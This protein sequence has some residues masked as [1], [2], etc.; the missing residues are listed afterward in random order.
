MPGIDAY[1]FG[2][3]F[4]YPEEG[5]EAALATALLRLGIAASRR[6]DGGFRI[7]ESD[8]PAFKMYAGGRVRYSA[9]EVCGLPAV[10]KAA[11][12]HIPTIISSVLSLFLVIFLSGLVWD[13]RIE[14]AESIPISEIEQRVEQS[15]LGIGSSW[16]RLDTSE[17]ETAILSSAPE[18]AWVQIN[19]VG[20]VAYVIVREREQIK[21]EQIEPY[22]CSN[23]VASSDGVI[24]E[25]TVLEGIALVKPGD[26][27]KMGD[28][29]ISGITEDE[30]GTVF[31]AAK[32]KV[33]AHTAGSL[34]ATAGLSEREEV[35]GEGRVCA[36]SLR[37]LGRNINIFKN[38]GNS[39]DECAIIEDEVVYLHLFGKRLP[40]LICRE[41]EHTVYE[42]A[43]THT[44]SE[45]PA[46]AAERLERLLASAL[47]GADLIKLKTSGE[48]TAS[49][50]TL[51]ARYVISR[52]IGEVV[53]ID[54]G[55]GSQ[56]DK[57]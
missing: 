18:I 35:Q 8:F 14:G 16:S 7:R 23:I 33:I 4:I 47:S 43:I 27:V 57:K 17:I 36:L 37:V 39:T 42:S 3:R 5:K 31:T 20:T 38:Y 44:A 40:I 53:G 2:Y 46:L 9:S 11:L 30:R 26:V 13:V 1:I 12:R 24:E 45:L 28:I 19:R 10:L 32:G 29:L 6:A 50:Y 56:N 52:D 41:R 22:G 15:G 48:Y 49:G 54:L 21:E 55:I 34:A 25:I 51:T